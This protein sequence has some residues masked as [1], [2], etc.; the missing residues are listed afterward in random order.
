MTT[1]DT[2][3]LT[4]F[5][6]TDLDLRFPEPQDFVPATMV[7]ATRQAIVN[8]GCY[9]PDGKVYVEKS[10]IPQLLGTDKSGANQFFNDLPNSEKMQNG[11]DRLVHTAAVMGEISRRIQEPFPAN[12]LENLKY[13]EECLRAFRDHPDLEKRRIVREAQNTQALSGLKE[14]MIR[15]EGVTQCQVTGQPLDPKAH[16]HHIERRADKPSLCLDANNLVVVNPDPH[17]EI[18]SAGAHSPQKLEALAM[19]KGWPWRA[20]VPV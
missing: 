14:R 11:K 13:N 5:K 17:V 19:E 12:K 7:V 3:E 2:K 4:L 9:T 18:H 10:A 15:A 20:D 8:K 16:V 1:P 6:A